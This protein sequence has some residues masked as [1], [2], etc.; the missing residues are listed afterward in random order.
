MQ[1]FRVL[2]LLATHSGRGRLPNSPGDRPQAIDARARVAGHPG[3]HAG[4]R[5]GPRSESRSRASSTMT[6]P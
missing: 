6:P 3:L 5:P 2:F 1:R 4:L